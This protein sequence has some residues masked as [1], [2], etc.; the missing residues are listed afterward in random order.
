MIE[1][2]EKAAKKAVALAA[3]DQ[4]APILRVGVK[5]GGCSGMSYFIDFD[6]P[7]NVRDTDT[8]LE[9]G[10]LKVVVDPKSLKFIDG[11]RLDFESNLLN[12]GFRFHNPNAKRSCSCGE[13]F[14]V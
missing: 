9:I 11:M 8:V 12:G 4:K 2:T 7:E 1:V 5:G 3:R 14:T 13:S 10:E 6:P